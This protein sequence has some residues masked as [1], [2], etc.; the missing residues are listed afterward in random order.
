R[1][2][3]GLQMRTSAEHNSA[4]MGAADSPPLALRRSIDLGLEP[5][6]AGQ[7]IDYLEIYEPD[8]AADDLQPALRY[9]ASLFVS[10]PYV[11]AQKSK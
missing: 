8:V 11:A 3:T 1:V 2:I 6:N 9:G 7:R 4:D 10:K 5:N